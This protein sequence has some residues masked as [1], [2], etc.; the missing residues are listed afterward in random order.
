MSNRSTPRWNPLGARLIAA[1]GVCLGLFAA[2]SAAAQAPGSPL[3]PAQPFAQSASIDARQVERWVMT[4]G[5]NGGQPFVIV[6]KRATEVFVFDGH[7]TLLGETSALIGSARGDDSS[8]GIGERKPCRRSVPT[9]GPRRPGASW[10]RSASR[11]ARMTFSGST[12]Q[13]RSRCTACWRSTVASTGCSGS[14][15][16]RRWTTGSRL[17]ASSC[18][19]GDFTTAFIDRGVP[20]ATSGIVYMTPLEVKSVADVFFTASAA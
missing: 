18:A 20:P 1:A 17:A 15:R 19:G 8:P 10:P 7:G 9:S 14:P 6:D 2:A 13:R 11:W 5:D 3:D 16:C 4:T 12:T